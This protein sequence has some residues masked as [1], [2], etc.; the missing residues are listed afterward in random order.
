MCTLNVKLQIAC[1]YTSK[2]KY[3]INDKDHD[4]RYKFVKNCMLHIIFDKEWFPNLCKISVDFCIMQ[5]KN[6]L[7]D[8]RN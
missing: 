3:L 2:Y 1:T 4:D 6:I 8:G 7:N 5:E